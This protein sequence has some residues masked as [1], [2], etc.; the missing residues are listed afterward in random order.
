MTFHA[1]RGIRRWQ[2]T[3][4]MIF[5]LG[6]KQR[7]TCATIRLETNPSLEPNMISIARYARGWT[8]L[9]LFVPCWWLAASAA[10]CAD[11]PG[12]TPQVHDPELTVTLFAASPDIVHPIGV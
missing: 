12:E 7:A 11:V 3:N 5:Q 2:S 10:L 8:S 9:A 1:T 4:K 6:L